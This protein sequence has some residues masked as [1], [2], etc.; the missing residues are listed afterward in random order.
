MALPK[1]KAHLELQ[2]FPN[3]E[4]V[5]ESNGSTKGHSKKEVT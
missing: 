3:V 4:D 2:R 1:I 5:H